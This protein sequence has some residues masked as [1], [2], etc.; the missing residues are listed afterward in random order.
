MPVSA[1]PTELLLAYTAGEDTVEDLLPAVYDE[2]RRIARAHLRRLGSD[3]TLSTTSLVHEAYLK[4]F[5]QTRVT[6]N[7][8]AH[9]L[10]LASQAMRFLLIDHARKKNAK[11]HGGELGRVSLDE[12]V[13]RIEAQA[14][15]L[16]SIDTALTRLA[17]HDERMAQVIE[18]QFFGGMTIE[19]TAAALDVSPSTVDRD[20]ALGRARLF[21]LLTN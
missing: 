8:R 17:E 3:Q 11:K 6:W 21:Q 19:E 20:R 14:A 13:H 4:L 7:D 2:L 10:A 5:D 15:D 18:C 16:L 12:S 1:Q 9:F